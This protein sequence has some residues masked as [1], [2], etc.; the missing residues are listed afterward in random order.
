MNAGNAVAIG[1][2]AGTEYGFYASRAGAI[3]ATNCVASQMGGWHFFA[4]E[5]GFIY[6]VN[7]WARYNGSG[8][9][10]YAGGN[11]TVIAVGTSTKYNVAT[12]YSPAVTPPAWGTSSDHG[13]MYVS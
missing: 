5:A 8:N 2:T 10:W 12:P 9:G 13:V 3:E 6:A 4:P 1:A 7:T 11:G